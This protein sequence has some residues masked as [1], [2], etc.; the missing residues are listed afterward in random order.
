MAILINISTCWTRAWLIFQWQIRFARRLF[1]SGFLSLALFCWFAGFL[2]ERD[3]LAL[4]FE[5]GVPPQAR[6]RIF[7]A[8]IILRE[9]FQFVCCFRVAP[10][11]MKVL[12]QFHF[13]HSSIKKIPFL[14]ASKKFQDLDVILNYYS[15]TK[16]V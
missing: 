11:L 15:I 6:S 9:W 7:F 13:V 2:V 16:L 12:S 1:L 3:R 8:D 14:L 4:G 5:E 10:P